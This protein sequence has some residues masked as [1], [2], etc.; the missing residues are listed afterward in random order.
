MTCLICVVDDDASFRSAITSLLHSI[1]YTVAAF[2][3]AEEFLDS[4]R[5]ADT[6]C[7]ISDVQMSG[8][9]G[10]ELQTRLRE[11]GQQLPIIFVAASPGEKAREQA[12]RSGALAFLGKPFSEDKLMSLLD[13]VDRD[14]RSG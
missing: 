3:S 10:F 8:M 13:Q 11:N 2:G 7:L 9:N 6:A 5:V 1:G 12:V 4:G 14:L